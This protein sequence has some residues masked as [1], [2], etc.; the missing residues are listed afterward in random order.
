MEEALS[1]EAVLNDLRRRSVLRRLA[2]EDPIVGYS[3]SERVKLDA[4]VSIRNLL[5][6][7]PTRDRLLEAGFTTV[8]DVRGKTED[9][10]RRIVPGILIREAREIVRFLDAFDE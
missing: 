10:L 8:G 2:G 6:S 9:E 4:S 3:Y 7:I 1:S 5:I